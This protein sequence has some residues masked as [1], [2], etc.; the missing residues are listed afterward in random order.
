MGSFSFRIALTQADVPWYH[1]LAALTLFPLAI[2]IFV[3][4]F[5][6]YKRVE[7][8]K[9]MVSVRYPFRFISF[10]IPLKEI[11][12]W[13]ET[14]VKAKTGN[15]REIEINSASRKVSINLQEHSHYLDAL[16]YLE[17]KAVRTKIR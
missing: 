9:E 7:F 15:Y 3:R 5:W 2:V 6:A 10:S 17:K 8:G 14:S 11:K 1:Y 4:I 13:K 12:T 16:K